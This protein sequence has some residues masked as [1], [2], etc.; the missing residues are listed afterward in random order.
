MNELLDESLASVSTPH[1]Q[2]SDLLKRR[3]D[4]WAI[5]VPWVISLCDLNTVDALLVFV[6]LLGEKCVSK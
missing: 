5:F 6:D 2:V 4:M 3:N 1:P